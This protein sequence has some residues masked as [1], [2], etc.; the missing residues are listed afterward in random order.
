VELIDASS[1][2]V[3]LAVNVLIIFPVSLAVSDLLL[4]EQAGE[5]YAKHR[6]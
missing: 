6:F 3:K 1:K 5:G 2:M 4:A